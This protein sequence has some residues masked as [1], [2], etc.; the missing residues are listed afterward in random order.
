MKQGQFKG[1]DSYLK[2]F[3]ANYD[4]LVLAGG[5]HIFC[6]PELVEKTGATATDDEIFQEEEKFKAI[7]LIKRSDPGRYGIVLD[8]LKNAAFVGRDEYPSSPADVHDLLVRRSGFFNT[9]MT[10]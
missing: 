2:R 6:S 4:T 8:E 1:D 3:C 5:K 7:C 9:N 10:G